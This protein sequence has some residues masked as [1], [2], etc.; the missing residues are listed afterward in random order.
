MTTS[1]EPIVVA[2][3]YKF[4]PM[5]DLTEIRARL[6]SAADVAGT[7]GTLLIAPEGI[8]GTV[9]GT[10]GGI[11]NLLATIRTLP[12]CDDLEHKEAEAE[13]LPFARMKVRIKREIVTMGVAELDPSTNAGTYVA[14]P[15]WNAL[16]S[17]PDVM[18]VDARNDYEHA[19]G[20]FVG[21]INPKTSSFRE[22]PGW[23]EQNLKQHE[24]T[25]IAMFCT[26]GIRCEKSTAF[27]KALGFRDVYHLKG[28]ILK[29][30]EEIPPDRS[31]WHGACF[32]FDERVSVGHGL[33]PGPHVLCRSCGWAIEQDQR[34]PRCSGD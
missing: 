8:N 1:P 12:G 5:H 28:G 13:T 9:A 21:A 10:R 22:L 31:L 3:L 11:D 18:I 23:L 24:R 7:R 2:A 17:D 16:I 4:T 6:C 15:D 19:I 25:K 26:G 34:C 14:P 32:V 30:L 20:S 33:E 29:Y 27:L